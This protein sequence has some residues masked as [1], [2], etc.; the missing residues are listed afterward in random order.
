M[1]NI[2]A[3]VFGYGREAVRVKVKVLFMYCTHKVF[4]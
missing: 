1:Q 3:G 2:M 4:E